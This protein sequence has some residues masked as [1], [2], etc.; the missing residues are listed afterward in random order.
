MREVVI[1]ETMADMD[2]NKDGYVTLEEYIGRLGGTE[3]WDGSGMQGNRCE[4]VEM[5][6]LFFCST[7]SYCDLVLCPV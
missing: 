3:D 4:A 6:G 2:K 7:T 5:L 1:D